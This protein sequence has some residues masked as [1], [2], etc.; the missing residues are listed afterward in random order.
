MRR[1]GGHEIAP[2]RRGPSSAIMRCRAIAIM[3]V[4]Q[5]CL[6]LSVGSGAFAQTQR[7]ALKSG[8]SVTLGP[9]YWVVNCRS[10]MVGLPEIEILDGPAGLTLSLREAMVLP[11]R[12][13]CPAKVAGALLT[14]TASDIKEPIEAK[15]T[16]RLKYTTKDGDRQTSN[17]YGVSLFP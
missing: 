4:A 16:Y 8:E 2:I 15:L 1:S 6:V 12:Q 9:V 10:T 7:I 14:A 5:A 17:I 11:R 3:L 13:N